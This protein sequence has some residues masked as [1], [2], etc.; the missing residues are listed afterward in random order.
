M[1]ILMLTTESDPGKKAE[2]KDAGA[3][4]WINKPFDAEKLVAVTKKLVG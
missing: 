2:G 4:G 1:P 3:T